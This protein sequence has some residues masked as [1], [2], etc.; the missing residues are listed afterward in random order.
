MYD[1]RLN[2][3]RKELTRKSRSREP[4]A[5]DAKARE[6]RARP[7]VYRVDFSRIPTVSG[8]HGK[9]TIRDYKRAVKRKKKHPV[10]NTGVLQ[11]FSIPVMF[12]N[13]SYLNTV[14]VLSF[15]AVRTG[16]VFRY[17]RRGLRIIFN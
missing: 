14:H 15:N 5:T 8:H 17:P 10:Q 2:P 7:H 4:R 1:V 9:L 11:S 12:T 6:N 13:G 3:E 16:K